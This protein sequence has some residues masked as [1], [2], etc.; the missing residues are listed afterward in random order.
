M[1]SAAIAGLGT[2]LARAGTTIAELT[3]IGGLDL[4]RDTID[5]TNHQSPNQYR[6]YIAGLK[7]GGEMAIEGNLIVGDTDGQLGLL[8]DLENGTLQ[9]FVVTFPA[10]ITA[11]FTFTALVTAFKTGDADI[12][13]KVTFSATLKISGKP[14]LAV[15]ASNNLTGLTVSGAGTVF[16]PTFAAGVYDY[17]VNIATGVATVTITP[18]AAAGTITI[19]AN[20]ASQVVSSG[21][22]SSAITLGA[23]G[24]IVIATVEVKETGKTAKTYTLRLTRAAS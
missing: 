8:A 4:K 19:A 18:T 9:N 6:E 21:Q 14:T 20:G 12:E 1:P 5:V 23:A 15:A 7:D 24:S 16:V 22:A 11:T 13:G 10:T 3:K 17:V 2:T